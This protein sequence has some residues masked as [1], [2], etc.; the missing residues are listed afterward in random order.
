MRYKI[1]SITV[2]LLGF[3][4]NGN[5]QK[6]EFSYMDLLTCNTFSDPQISP[7]GDWIV[8]QR[9][10]MDVMKDKAIG[11][12]WVDQIRWLPASKIDF[13]GG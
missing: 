6:K 2:L 3:L 4:F 1:L 8:Y 13:E 9:M 7:N 10:E 11:D 12:L 5:A